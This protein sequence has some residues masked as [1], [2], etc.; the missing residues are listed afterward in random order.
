MAKDEGIEVLVFDHADGDRFLKMSSQHNP[1]SFN[2]GRAAVL[3][4]FHSSESADTP[5]HH[6]PVKYDNVQA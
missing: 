4:E 3:F 2:A 5:F 6:T 1:T